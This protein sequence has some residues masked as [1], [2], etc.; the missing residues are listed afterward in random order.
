MPRRK[1]YYGSLKRRVMKVRNS[2]ILF[3]TI[4][5]IIFA[6]DTA[7]NV[8]PV[9]EQYYLKYF[10]GDGDNE[11]IDL[12]VNPDNTFV[13]LGSSV[14]QDGSRKIFVTKTDSEGEAIWEKRFGNGD[15]YP[16]DIEPIS[17]GY[18]IV[19]NIDIGGGLYDFKLIRIDNDG[20]KI[21]SLVYDLLA[22]QFAR[23]VTPLSDGG[24]FVVGN[25]IDSDS[26]NTGDNG[27]PVDEAED[28]LYVRF[29][30]TFTRDNSEQDR[31]G[32]SSVG[33]AVK[34][35][36]TT[37]GLF[38]TSEFS[39]KLT[40]G[41]PAV[42]ADYE[43]NFGFKNFSIGPQ[44]ISGAE[45]IIG[46]NIREER[47]NQTV[48]SANADFYS[49]GTSVLLPNSNSIFITKVRSQSGGPVKLFE[50][51]IG[52]GS[53]EGV[54]IS[55]GV[56]SCYVLANKINES[57]GTRDIWLTK[58]S[59]FTGSQDPAW[60]NG[61]TFGSPTNDDTASVV[62]EAP[63]GDI[64]VLGTIGLTNQRKIALIKLTPDGKFV[65]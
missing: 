21:D 63:N 5:F 13:I 54:S 43:Q 49:I 56:S 46:D 61:F 32:S 60:V 7:S 51:S 17:G 25:T 19:S 59:A 39:D 35:Y 15:E 6:C 14:L 11:G 4:W 55:S 34:V 41:E 9:F 10:G 2:H 62:V 64:V 36:E 22:D 58:I 42:E 38:M 3:M 57:D 8:E 30:N 18:I 40:N 47:M 27:L 52:I 50:S 1:V 33:S 53:N 48:V 65:P 28:L 44:S 23:S 16:Q 20:N 45:L 31:V 12:V 37:P 29:D 24:F 26:L